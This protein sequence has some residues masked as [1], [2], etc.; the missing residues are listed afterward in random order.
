MRKDA[1]LGD[2]G[3]QGMVPVVHRGDTCLSFLEAKLRPLGKKVLTFRRLSEIS[4]RDNVLDK[5]SRYPYICRR[6]GELAFRCS[7][8]S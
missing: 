1:R 3:C 7:H 2:A 6:K 4:E 8:C 5:M